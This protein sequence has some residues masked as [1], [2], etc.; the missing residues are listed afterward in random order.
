MIKTSNEKVKQ[1]YD[2]VQERCL[3][4][5]FSRAWDREANIKNITRMAGEILTGTEPDV[6][7]PMD[8]QFFADAK[9]M[10]ADLKQRFDW[11][12]AEPPE[13]IVRLMSELKDELLDL[14]VTHSTNSELNWSFY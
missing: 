4:Q 14:A 8:K 10:V 11:I 13:S 6:K 3:W 5:F 7:T 1:L 12:A 2:Y 9:W